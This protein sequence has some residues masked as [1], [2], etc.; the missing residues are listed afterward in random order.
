VLTAWCYAN[1]IIGEAQRLSEQDFPDVDQ[2]RG[3]RI[4]RT[5]PSLTGLLT[6]QLTAFHQFVMVARVRPKCLW[7]PISR[8][9]ESQITRLAQ[10]QVLEDSQRA[11]PRWRD[12]PS[13]LVAALSSWWSRIQ[14][15][16]AAPV[17]AK[18]AAWCWGMPLM[19]LAALVLFTDLDQPLADPA[20]GRQAEV[21]R[22]MLA[23][24][25]WLLPRFG[26]L[27]YYEKPPLQ[28]W[29]T[30]TAYSIWGP[31][32][33]VARLVPVSAAWL[34]VLLTYVWGC[35]FLG[36]RSGFMGGI[37]LCLTPGFALVGRMVV[38][39]SLLATCVLAA[40]FAAHA[41][42]S[43]PTLH[44][45]WWV[46][47]AGAC[48]LGI[49]TKGP[50]ALALL[51]PP[52]L[53][54]NLLTTST[55]RCRVIPWFCHLFVALGVSA[56]WYIAMGLREPG[57]LEHFFWR[58]NVLRFVEPF[59]H[60]EPWWY[61]VPVLFA[62]TLPWSFLWPWLAYFLGSRQPSIA[63][64]RSSAL[65][66]AVLAGGWCLLFYSLAGCKSPPYLAPALAPLALLIGACGEVLLFQPA[67]KINRFLSQAAEV[68]PPRATAFLL[69]ISLICPL[70][71]GWYGFT[72]WPW[73]LGQ[74]ATVLVL[75]GLWWRFV[76]ETRPVTAWAACAL[77]TA[78]WITLGGRDVLNAFTTR[79]S[80][81]AAARVA[82]RWHDRTDYPLV[83]YGR[84]WPS[85][86]FYL[87]RDDV[88]CIEERSQLL[89]YL[90]D[91]P[92]ALILVESGPLLDDLLSALP[93][94]VEVDVRTP[95]RRGQAAVVEVRQIK[96]DPASRER[97]RPE[98]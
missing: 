18:K 63:A 98:V 33:W 76:G 62:A 57:Y 10:A 60:Q 30:A 78:L 25:D 52:V 93:R 1:E 95:S 73:V 34:A 90:Q 47:S 39:D 96:S 89:S 51:V 37:V 29:M 55:A 42:L 40:W 17:S 67:G 21:P 88:T 24:H 22:E 45:G 61:Y 27:P 31:R 72:T 81:A 70:V 71:A 54:Y 91:R 13:L 32:A 19:A 15:P 2:A 6:A 86:W 59:H 65:G 7:E 20:E 58:N 38:L 50:V 49:L 11:V 66:F 44:W 83:C 26:G 14:F 80:V 82:R 12:L 69:F 97:K 35:R 28:Y 48:S 85:A 53:L 94:S 9:V 79:H 64:L 92:G 77:A 4:Q 8:M 56:P 84:Q 16:G 3:T 36:V 5:L 23:H 75:L 68:L 74:C 43:R 46:G 87:R 41:A